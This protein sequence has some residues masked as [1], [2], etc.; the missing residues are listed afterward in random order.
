MSYMPDTKSYI[1]DTKPDVQVV[2]LTGYTIN[3]SRSELL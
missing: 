1:Q 3:F 2:Y